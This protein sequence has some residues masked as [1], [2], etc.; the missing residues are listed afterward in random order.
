MYYIGK[1]I[2]KSKIL[3]SIVSIWFSV[4]TCLASQATSAFIKE[5]ESLIKT[6]NGE[7]K[8]VDYLWKNSEK[9]ERSDLLFLTKILV[10]RKAYSDILKASDLALARNSKDA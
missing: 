4:S 5:A 10:K 1:A 2:H 8:A 6:E 9:L 3:L 7:E